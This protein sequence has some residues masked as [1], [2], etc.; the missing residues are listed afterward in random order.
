MTEV[1]KVGYAMLQTCHTH[2][3]T[4]THTPPS[5]SVMLGGL[6]LSFELWVYVNPTKGRWTVSAV[7]RE[8]GIGSVWIGQRTKIG[9]NTKKRLKVK[10]KV[11]SNWSC[12]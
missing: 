2:T 1:D 11:T 4:H 3:H 12:A 10:T 6:S 9:Q 5:S 7:I 8:G